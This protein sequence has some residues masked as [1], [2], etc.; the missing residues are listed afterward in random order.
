MASAP[1]PAPDTI[2]SP[3]SRRRPPRPGGL[4]RAELLTERGD[5]RTAR[6]LLG[7]V[8]RA[9][10]AD[11]VNCNFDSRREA[12]LC[13]FVE[14]RRAEGLMALSLRAGTAA[15]T[16]GAGVW[17]LSQGDL[18]L[19]LRTAS[20]RR[21]WPSIQALAGALP[22]LGSGAPG[23]LVASA[24]V[25]VASTGVSAAF[26]SSCSARPEGIA[27]TATMNASAIAPAMA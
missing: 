26:G 4:Q 1:A 8:G 24:G 13:G 17:A 18:E 19:L 27:R 14:Y 21:R 7:E 15:E 20:P 3:S 10:G 22:A 23:V 5:V 12:A 16:A 6:E 25:L 9:S 11:I 2:A